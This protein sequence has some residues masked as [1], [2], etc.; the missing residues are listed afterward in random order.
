[1]PIILL[2]NQVITMKGVITLPEKYIDNFTPQDDTTPAILRGCLLTDNPGT[3]RLVL[4]GD[5]I[6]QVT[7]KESYLI[8][9]LREKQFDRV[10]YLVSTSATNISPIEEE[11][12]LPTKETL[13][14]LPNTTTI[15]VN[16]IETVDGFKRSLSCINCSKTLQTN[17][18]TSAII[19]CSK[20]KATQRPSSCKPI[21]SVRIAVKFKNDKLTWL[22]A[23]DPILRQLL[24]HTTEN[25]SLKD[26][27]EEQVYTQL[28]KL[29]NFTLEYSNTSRVIKNIFL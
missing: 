10:N 14:K 20:C 27:S 24:D 25:F 7:T 8:S 5:T 12:P 19:K 2:S 6:K 18:T 16:Q 29:Q 22:T 3:V 17:T 28:F 21:T 26:A 13:S 15:T 9:N 23:F 1:M 11:F 4:R